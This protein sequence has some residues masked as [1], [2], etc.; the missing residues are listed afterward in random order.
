MDVR[1]LLPLIPGPLQ[2]V[3]KAVLDRM[4]TL[5]KR[6]AAQAVELAR[7]SGLLARQTTTTGEKA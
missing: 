3:A 6:Q 5:E 2:A 1:T 7:L 4:D